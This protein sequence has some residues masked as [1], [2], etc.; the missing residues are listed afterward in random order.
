MAMS[1]DHRLRSRD[2]P[3]QFGGTDGRFVHLPSD[4]F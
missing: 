4:D 1:L 2:L 3:R